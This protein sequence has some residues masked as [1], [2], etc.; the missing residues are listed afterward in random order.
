MGR[1]QESAGLKRRQSVEWL[2]CEETSEG[3]RKHSGGPEAER[4]KAL[5]RCRL[6]AGAAGEKG[7]KC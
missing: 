6:R 4:D 5:Q 7:T 3:D 1:D 2:S